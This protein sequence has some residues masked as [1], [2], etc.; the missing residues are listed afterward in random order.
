MLSAGLTG[1]LLRIKRKYC[2]CH[3][4]TEKAEN[5]A[6]IVNKQTPSLELLYKNIGDV[7]TAN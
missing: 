2:L 5:Q 3:Q 4:Q 6:T 1:Y 7:M